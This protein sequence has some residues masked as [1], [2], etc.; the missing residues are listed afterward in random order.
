MVSDYQYRNL[1]AEHFAVDYII[2]DSG[3]TVTGNEG[4][5]P[6]ISGETFCLTNDDIKAE[7]IRINESL[8]S[9]KNLVFGKIEA[10]RL[11]FSFK[12]NLDLPTDLTTQEIDVYLYFD[13]DSSTL[14]KVGRYTI[15]SD[16]YSENNFVRS[17]TAYDLLYY[18]KDLDITEWY[19][20]YFGDGLKHKIIDILT[21]EEAN[22]GKMGLFEYLQEVEDLPFVLASGQTL[23]NGDFMLGQTIES[24]SISFEFFMQRILEFNGAFGHINRAGEFEFV[25][26]EWYDAEPARTIINDDRIPPTEHDIVSTWGIGGIDVYD[27][28]NIRV[29][30]TRNTNKKK[31]SIYNIVDSFVFAGRQQGDADVESALQELQRTINH[32]NYKSS[33]IKASGDLCVEVGDR[34]NI[35]LLP[36]EGEERG[37]FRS[38]VLIR[39]F[40]GIQG[41]TDVYQANGDKKQPIYQ[42]DNDRWHDGDS[43]ARATGG[44]N[45]VSQLNDEHDKR[46]IELMRNYGYPMLD[47]PEVDLV[48]NREDGQVEI[49]WED[50]ADIAS[51]S[52]LPVAWAGTLV[53]RKEGTPPLHRWGTE[54]QAYGGTVLVDSTTRDAYKVNAYV[55]NTIQLNKRYYYAIMPYYVSLDDA[56]HPIKTYRWTKVISVDTHKSLTAP[57]ISDVTVSGVDAAVTYE[58]PVLDSGAYAACK[59]VAK[60]GAIPTSKTDGQK[61]IDI[62]A[63]GTSATVSGLDEL[64][65]YY[66]V[67][68]IDDTDGNTASSDPKDITTGIQPGYTFND[69]YYVGT[70]ACDNRDIPQVM[71]DKIIAL[72]SSSF[73]LNNSAID[74]LPPYTDQI[75]TVYGDYPL[76]GSKYSGSDKDQIAPNPIDIMPQTI[77]KG[78]LWFGFRGLDSSHNN[79]GFYVYDENGNLVTST[80]MS[81]NNTAWGYWAAY[82]AY[83]VP[84]HAEQKAILFGFTYVASV[85][86]YCTS[87]ESDSDT[88]KSKLYDVVFG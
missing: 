67:I 31:P 21:D 9:D 75:A 7:S 68:F 51:Y 57:T 10:A 86:Y 50:P 16:R 79:G 29:F 18:I 56:D 13:Y 4:M 32:Y 35:S 65:K 83:I 3:A 73:F 12:N 53:V 48:Y 62:S 39:T 44:S 87:T 80:S 69:T 19:Y 27:Q 63:S 55:D 88:V 33:N 71:K 77:G 17:I 72:E 61:I 34:I 66:F 37:W 45:G 1:F 5:L 81:M 60:K 43:D 85:G 8:C 52:P 36:D 84:N 2:V 58:I 38:Y 76:R 46:F 20:T 47:E 22:D 28:N 54:H 42:I 49:K 24:D 15:K 59:L 30:K 26:L 64:S 23:I 11:A 25:V 74:P 40:S 14:F 6:T 82:W 41:M 70:Y 78:S